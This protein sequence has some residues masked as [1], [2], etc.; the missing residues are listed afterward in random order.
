MEPDGAPPRPV[1]EWPGVRLVRRELVPRE[2]ATAAVAPP[3]P[4][5][6]APASAPASPLPPRSDP[7]P[8]PPPSVAPAEASIV[9]GP[10][11]SLPGF[12]FR[13]DRPLREDGQY[14]VDASTKAERLL[15]DEQYYGPDYVRELVER[16]AS[17]SADGVCDFARIVQGLL[18]RSS[19]LW[20]TAAPG[21]QAIQLLLN[22]EPP[23]RGGAASGVPA[24]LIG[25]R[26]LQ[27]A[28]GR[29]PAD[30][31]V[32]RASG[33]GRALPKTPALARAAA[34][35]GATAAAAAA[36]AAFSATPIGAATAVPG[37]P[38]PMPQA[39]SDEDR[40]L[41]GLTPQQVDDE[42]RASFRP[43]LTTADPNRYAEDR[44][45]IWAEAKKR[46][47]DYRAWQDQQAAVAAATGVA[48]AAAP[49]LTSDQRAEAAAHLKPDESLR[50]GPGEYIYDFADPQAML[51][52][53]MVDKSMT[54]ETKL[55][56]W[57]LLCGFSREFLP[58]LTHTRPPGTTAAT[59][60]IRAS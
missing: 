26:P 57:D 59:P 7:A 37:A 27:F 4:A 49:P 32:D 42:A 3:P 6:A 18:G 44:R 45:R 22:A 1:S 51:L 39:P 11:H 21:G 24:S 30:E 58:P 5:A 55:K 28:S 33:L 50:V 52:R 40:R 23:G 29:K 41:D 12:S 36:P 31:L 38:L 10:A 53:L 34:S 43:G 25:P 16:Y 19:N 14:W 60:T 17:A 48:T 13:G 8:P 15:P 35:A 54:G 9:D 47:A 56:A 20:K 46:V 2:A